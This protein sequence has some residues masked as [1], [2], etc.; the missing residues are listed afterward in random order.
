MTEQKLIDVNKLLEDMN[1][2][3]VDI[4]INGL[5]SDEEKIR[6]ACQAVHDH[7]IECINKQP[8]V[9]RFT[10]QRTQP[11][12]VREVVHARWIECDYKQLD[13]HGEVLTYHN[14]ALGCSNC[15]N[16][17]KKELLWRDNFCPNC[18]AQMDRREDNG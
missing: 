17:F 18:G 2:Y 10:E 15:R 11:T 8:V 9:P 7:A 12:E 4:E 5:D 6:K 14:A 16:A 3:N 1:N 13:S